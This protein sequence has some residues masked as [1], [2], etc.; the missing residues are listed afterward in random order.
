MA[1]EP[2]FWRGFVWGFVI[3]PAIATVGTALVGIAGVIAAKM[4]IDSGGD[5]R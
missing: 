1:K 4:T 3:V 5:G 2:G